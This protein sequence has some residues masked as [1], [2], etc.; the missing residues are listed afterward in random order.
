MSK[1]SVMLAKDYTP[2]VTNVKPP[3]SDP[4]C[5]PPVGWKASEKFDGYRCLFIGK[6]M[7]DEEKVFL[8]RSQKPFNAPDLFKLAMPD[9]DLD[10]DSDWMR[11]SGSCPYVLKQENEDE[12]QYLSFHQAEVSCCLLLST[13]S[14]QI[15]R[16]SFPLL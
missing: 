16:S 5:L 2:G 9:E 8:S 1:M 3:R 4:D 6:N 12:C 7:S 15:V 14:F 11:Q 13:H 10:G